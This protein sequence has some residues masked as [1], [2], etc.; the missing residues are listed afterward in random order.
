M[1]RKK[2]KVNKSQ[3]IREYFG[4]NPG[5]SAKDVAEGLRKKKIDVSLAMIANVKS[6][7]GLTKKRK[8]RG[9]RK[10]ISTRAARASHGKANG[11]VSVD[12][13]VDAKKLISKTG[14]AESAI[15]LIRAIEKL[16][17]VD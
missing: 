6:K 14:S 8:R 16:S 10:P 17:S 13:L 7:A 15:A 5:A 1:A 9:T 2:A 4:E 12:A 11:H 3:A